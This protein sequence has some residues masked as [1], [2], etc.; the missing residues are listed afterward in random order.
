MS[1]VWDW[2]DS[3]W[4]WVV[5]LRK[6]LFTD[7]ARMNALEERIDK[8]SD[9]L[10]TLKADFEAYKGAVDQRLADLAATIA[11]LLAGQL[12]P[13]KAQLIDDEINAARAEL[14]PPTP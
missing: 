2:I 9:V 6:R 14:N 1:N 8:M 3:T 11:G 4:S 12:D 13:A 7:E 10:D 5:W